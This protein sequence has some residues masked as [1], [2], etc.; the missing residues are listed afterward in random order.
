M[1]VGEN[2][3]A[4]PGWH[5]AQINIARMRAP[6][7][8][9]I[10]TEFAEAL[11]EVNA[12]ADMSPGFV[13]RLQDANCDATAIRAFADPLILVNMSVWTDLVAL[14]N[15]VYRT[16]HGRFFARRQAWF[17]KSATAHLAL[18]WVPA[19]HRPTVAEGK[20]RL[21]QLDQLGASAAAFT[22]RQPF[23]PATVVG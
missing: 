20:A 5:L 13:W 11:E 18:W 12:L 15:Y 1:G 9:P 16:M 3:A 21:E 10:M 4:T 8:D 19:G 17:E 23:P 6:L 14:Q 2:P 7:T 22:F